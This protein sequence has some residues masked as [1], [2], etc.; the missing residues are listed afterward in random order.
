MDIQ[1]LLKQ[2]SEGFYERVFGQYYGTQNAMTGYIVHVDDPEGG[3]VDR[4]K[5]VGACHASVNTAI[6]RDIAL[7]VITMADK[8]LETNEGAVQYYDWLINKSFFS[9]VFLC[10]DP[11]LSLRY[12]FVKRV[13]ISAAKW[14]GAAQLSRLSTSEF[15]LNMKAVYDILA[16]GFD[17]HPMLLTML[18]TEL[19]FS[20]DG[21]KINSG[22]TS[23]VAPLARSM[24]STQYS[25]LP[26]YV[27]DTV[28]KIKEACKDD[29][30]KRFDWI[31]QT[32]FNVSRWPSRSNY[33]LCQNAGDV[34]D[35][36]DTAIHT[37]ISG[38]LS[39]TSSLL[40]NTAK[41]EATDYAFLWEEAIID[42]KGRLPRETT[43]SG[44][45]VNLSSLEQLSKKLKL[46][47]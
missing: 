11:V 38:L 47:E 2:H 34:A 35:T 28:N 3:I 30:T 5:V 45:P 31:E 24:V 32:P 41:E 20:S 36:I 23:R 4:S 43:L 14:L 9:D 44:S 37:A 18:A 29:T 7:A 33:I 6:R 13:D 12:G 22:R 10:K 8:S 25:H 46:G 27:L 19:S 17:I 1:T 40:F 16:S 39:G 42:L 21:K 15:R 26:F